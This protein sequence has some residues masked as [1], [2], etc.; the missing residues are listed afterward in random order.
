[1]FQLISRLYLKVVE[2]EYL[3]D[4]S[5]C[6]KEGVEWNDGYDIPEY[7]LL[8]TNPPAV[9]MTH[10]EWIVMLSLEF[11]AYAGPVTG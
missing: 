2:V 1:M 9:L 8:K 4:I 11:L 7:D 10:T 3:V 6:H 5:I